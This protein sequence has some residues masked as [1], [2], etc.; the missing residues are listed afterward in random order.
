MDA[1][2]SFPAREKGSTVPEGTK[3]RLRS[4][5][6]LARLRFL[7]LVLALFSLLVFG[8][9]Q[10]TSSPAL[11]GSCHEMGLRARAWKVSPHARVKC[12]SCHVGTHAWYAF[13]QALLGR[14]Q[15]LGRVVVKHFSRASADP[16]D[17]RAPGAAPMSDSI[18]LQCHDPDRKPTAGLGIVIDHPKHAKRNKSCVSCHVTVA[19]PRP[20]RG[21][22][23]SF[24]G[25]CFTCHG[26]SKGSKAPATCT[27]C[28]PRDFRM[29]PASHGDRSKW[30]RG[31]G[32]VAAGDP[33]QCEMCHVRTLCDGCHGIPMPHPEGWG[34]RSGHPV[35]ASRNRQ[36]CA[37]CHDD[38]PDWC[39]MCH[40]K[41]YSP[42]KG[43][44]VKQ[45]FLEVQAKGA[46]MCLESCHSPV[47]C[48][49]CHVGNPSP[50]SGGAQASR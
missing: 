11:C 41:A 50:A 10:V 2:T 34:T 16:V 47:Y 14:G 27:L 20:S 15:L 48:S 32:V 35:Y 38:K 42:A 6:L 12:V 8:A 36:V 17:A 4:G 40:H 7:V 30:K 39:S 28:H 37:R 1:A 49:R 43:S 44:W 24:M 5:T 18:C 22:A 33:R 46:S 21:T 19:H 45:H 25:Q 26:A 23:L 13:P 31:H 3:I 29:V 9:D